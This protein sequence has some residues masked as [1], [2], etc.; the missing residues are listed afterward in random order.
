MAAGLSF[1]FYTDTGVKEN[2]GITI[3]GHFHG[4][5]SSVHHFNNIALFSF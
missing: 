4:P 5:Y 2:Y 1:I 3:D